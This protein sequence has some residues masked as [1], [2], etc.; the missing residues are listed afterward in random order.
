[1]TTN[2]KAIANRGWGPKALN[3][4]VLLHPEIHD[5]K[6]GGVALTSTLESTVEPEELNL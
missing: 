6:H 2:K 5:T 3:Y 1:V 4:N